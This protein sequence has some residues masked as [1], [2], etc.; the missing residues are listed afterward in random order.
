MNNEPKDI[1]NAA[2]GAS[3]TGLTSSLLNADIAKQ[4]NSDY[5]LLE[6]KSSPTEQ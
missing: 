4:N 2:T 3:A 5:I 6:R 1:F